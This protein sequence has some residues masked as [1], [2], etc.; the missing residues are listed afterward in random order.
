M[1]ANFVFGLMSVMLSGAVAQE[2]GVAARNDDETPKTVRPSVAPQTAPQATGARMVLP[3]VVEHRGGAPVDVVEAAERLRIDLSGVNYDADVLVLINGE[4]VTQDE[5]RRSMCLLAGS[6]EIDQFVTYILGQSLKEKIQAEGIAIESLEVSDEEV[7]KQFEAQKEMSAEMMKIDPEEWERQ[8]REVFGWDRYVEFQKVQLSF[9]KLVLP[10]PPPGFFE[11]QAALFEEMKVVYDQEKLAW[12]Q[13]KQEAERVAKEN[14]TEPEEIP[15]PEIPTPE[16]DLSFVPKVSMELL[17][18]S[19]GDVILAN[20]AR[21]QKIH[22]MLKR[23]IV[24]ALKRNLLADVDIRF[25][26]LGDNS[27]QGVFFT[28]DGTPVKTSEVYALIKPRL[29]PAIKA[30]ALQ[31]IL[32]L[33]A[34]DTALAARGAL[35]PAAEIDGPFLEM[36]KRYEGSLIPLEQAIV[37]RGFPNIH[38][39]R[40]YYRRKAAYKNMVLAQPDAEQKFEDHFNKGGKLFFENGGVDGTVLFIPGEDNDDTRNKM[41]AAMD[42]IANGE[43]FD[44]VAREVGQLPENRSHHKGRFAG[45]V[46]NRLRQLLQET[47]FTGFVSGYSVADEIFYKGVPG[48]VVGPVHRS[49]SEKSDRHDC[50]QFAVVLYN[51]QTQDLRRG[52]GECHGGLRGRDLSSVHD[53][54]LAGSRH[55]DPLAV[56][57]LEVVLWS[58][59]AAKVP[60]SNGQ[61]LRPAPRAAVCATR[62]WLLL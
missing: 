54:G 1:K 46:R 51:Q 17:G 36:K 24:A 14:G 48:Q 42:R 18:E 35:P 52:A 12:E 32:A 43:S 2:A 55:S 49:V 56:R 38:H 7:A 11:K 53:P 4:P 6:N 22:P 61:N 26:E 13:K 15:P 29:T 19:F 50:G 10:E 47:E 28:V 41:A 39:Y 62:R 20:Y 31:E 5:F 44:T 21:G 60:S 23:G 58:Q 9:E 37:L 27:S 16:A 34:V 25:P 33:R 8:V 57:P 59:G 45:L 3:S 40:N 30:L